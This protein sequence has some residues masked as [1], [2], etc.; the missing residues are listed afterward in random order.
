MSEL[1]NKHTRVLP[2][3]TTIIVFSAFNIILIGLKD[4]VKN[5]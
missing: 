5:I 1:L 4:I 3:G 2:I